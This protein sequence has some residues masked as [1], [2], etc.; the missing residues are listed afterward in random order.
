MATRQTFTLSYD[1]EALREGRMDVRE[2]APALLA[3]GDLLQQA[4]RVLNDERSSV[5][6]QVQ[7]QF[8]TGSFPIAF[9]V[10]QSLIEMAQDF[11]RHH[12]QIKDAKEILETLFFFAALPA[13][14]VTS[15]VKLLKWLKG[16]RPKP[17]QVSFTNNGTV[18][19]TI[20]D[21]TAETPEATYRVA[22]DPAI[23]ASLD[24]MVAPLRSEGIE[25][26]DIYDAEI[27]SERE[28]ITKSEVDYF[29]AEE[30]EGETLLDNTRDAVLSIVRLSFNREHKW[31]FTDGTTRITAKIQD[32]HFWDQIQ[33]RAVA[34]SKGDHIL[35][36][37]R[38]RTFRRDNGDLKSEYFVERV[39]RL[40]HRPQQQNLL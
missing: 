22:T 13:T 38:T 32:G 9:V 35:V 30:L 37:L 17:G 1:G 23:R 40:I 27:S 16:D 39:V 20:G 36:S 7:G 6:V 8:R 4:N 26:L 21:R 5:S 2:L 34:F 11:L 15:V 25:T 12:S 31:G 24:R 3:A 28:V 19:I 29:S 10:D 18:V 33:N 14:G